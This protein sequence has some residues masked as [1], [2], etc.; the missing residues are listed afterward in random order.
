MGNDWGDRMKIVERGLDEGMKGLEGE[1][2]WELL[3]E[4]LLEGLE[5]WEIRLNGGVFDV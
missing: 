1:R 2:G 3:G 5:D 4:K